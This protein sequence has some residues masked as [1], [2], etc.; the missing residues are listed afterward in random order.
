MIRPRDIDR[1][2][3]WRYYSDNV[4][5][6]PGLK[7]QRLLAAL[8]QDQLAI[9]ANVRRQTVIRLEQDGDATP[10]TVRKLA[11]ALGVQPATLIGPE[12]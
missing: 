3:V 12:N 10:T 8:T 9:K 2:R 5:G 6:V 11:D 7:R 1:T 4:V